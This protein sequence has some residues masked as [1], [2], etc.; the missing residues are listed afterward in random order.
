MCLAPH[1]CYRGGVDQLKAGLPSLARLRKKDSRSVVE[2]ERT[3]LLMAA[4]MLVVSAASA[5]A[6]AGGGGQDG[7]KVGQKTSPLGREKGQNE[8]QN[9]LRTPT[10]ENSTGSNTATVKPPC[11]Y[12]PV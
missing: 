9:M 10:P 5:L 8:S 6:D 1:V 11:V 4:M 3:V 7:I 2:K 12:S